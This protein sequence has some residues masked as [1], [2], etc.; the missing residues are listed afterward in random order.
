MPGRKTSGAPR[1]ARAKPAAQEQPI[2]AE[3]D[4]L[5]DDLEAA[6]QDGDA[7]RVQALSEDLWAARKEAPEALTRRLIAG[8]VAVP[9]F[10]FELLAGL[11]GSRAPTY[12]RR[13]AKDR[14]AD[15]LTRFAAQR[16]AGW[17]E[18]TEQARR[19][20]FL[21]ALSDA[22]GTLVLAATNAS[23]AWPPNGEALQEVLRYLV[24]LPPER[25]REIAARIVA[26][27]DEGITWVLHAFLQFDDPALQRLALEEVAR[28]RDPGSAA[29]VDRLA[30]TATD[31]GVR[32][33]AVALAPRLRLRV[34]GGA[35]A[36]PRWLPPLERALVSAIDGDGGQVLLIIRRAGAGVFLFADF[37]HN[38]DFGLKDTFGATWANADQVE[39]MTE[40]LEGDGIPLVEVDEAVARG[41]L[42]HA[43][44][45]N[46]ALG[47][48]LPPAF[49]L[50]EPL[51]HDAYPAA[52]DEPVVAPEL[53]DAPYAGRA[54]LLEVSDELLEHPF[55]D[56]W[57]F[58][59]DEMGP[60]LLDVPQPGRSGH[61]T[62]RQFRP[63]I[64]RL[65]PPETRRQLRGRLRRQAWLLERD[66]D[67]E[68][69]D[70][71]LA[72]AAALADEAPTPPYQHPLLR[73]MVVISLVNLSGLLYLE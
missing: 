23:Q 7:E 36:P 46:V 4:R 34:V 41:V 33:E 47:R 38:D 60:A 72:A 35:T 14:A 6:I 70:R 13:I 20:S 2:S 22:D 12:L 59:P 48:Q 1:K 51:A 17:P 27:P 57:F 53:D 3:T 40:A 15:D 43:V 62:D 5:L 32:A 19:R 64:E 18:A 42:A 24:A 28:R 52:P 16:R 61:L 73:E 65:V 21:N 58:N 9:G 30:R 45:R 37:F 71:A 10:A 39:A 55:F 50:W 25:R 29:A 54:E 31:E 26:E 44:A 67:E 63:L 69:R 68:D 49:E 56:A 66:G 8:R 11:A